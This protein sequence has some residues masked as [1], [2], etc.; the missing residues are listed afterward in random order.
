MSIK[1]EY[2]EAAHDVS[3]TDV[4]SGLY[5][6]TLSRRGRG[7]VCCCPFHAEK[8]PSFFM[9]ADRNTYHCFG[10]GKGGDTISFVME[11]GGKTFEEAVRHILARHRPD[12]NLADITEKR[13]KE[14]ER[15]YKERETLYAY[16]HYAHEYFREQYL[17]NNEESLACRRYAER[18]DGSV[19]GHPSNG[20]WDTEFCSVCE[21]GYSPRKGNG[22]MI[23]LPKN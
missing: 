23:V 4:V 5:D 19:S 22:L 10:C 11:Y 15:A 14:E 20:R 1:R 18:S 6:G 21:L 17:A 16:N 8:T 13:S 3:I 9:S 2:I 12:I 7:S